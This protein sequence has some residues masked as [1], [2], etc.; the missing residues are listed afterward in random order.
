MAIDFTQKKAAVKPKDLPTPAGT[1][2]IPAGFAKKA[3]V[4]AAPS[5]AELEAA[6]EQSPLK[7]PGDNAPKAGSSE[8]AGQGVKP[9][10]P[11]KKTSGL[12]SEIPIELYIRGTARK[13]VLI[14]GPEQTI[15]AFKAFV[16]D[17]G[18][19]NWEALQ[20]LVQNKPSK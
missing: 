1:A 7:H 17:R 8:K 11:A 5:I 20:L 10:K 15:E 13:S 9:R 14:E 2:K 19:K 6:S 16:K 12:V 4:P 18:V 3:K